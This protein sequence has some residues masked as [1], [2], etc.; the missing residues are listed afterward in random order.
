MLKLLTIRTLLVLGI[1]LMTTSL[2]FAQDASVQNEEG[3]QDTSKV[4][5]D[6]QNGSSDADYEAL[7]K[8]LYGS[9]ADRDAVTE[10]KPAKIKK[11]RKA[12][13]R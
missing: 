12:N 6:G 2:V 9:E 4:F 5:G 11:R 10:E 1:V 13:C 3:A 8:E 7:I